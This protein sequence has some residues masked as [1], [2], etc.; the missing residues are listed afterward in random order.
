[1]SAAATADG[2]LLAPRAGNSGSGFSHAMRGLF[3]ENGTY[4]WSVQAVDSSFTGSV[5]A[6]EQT[7]VVKPLIYFA[8]PSYSIAEGNTSRNLEIRIAG[9]LSGH[10]SVNYSVTGGT[11]TN[12]QDFSL[13]SGTLSFAP[14]ETSKNITVT[15]LD[16]SLVEWNETV[17]VSLS[18]PLGA[19]LGTPSQTTLTITD[20]DSF[21]ETPISIATSIG[22]TAAW[23]D[24][25]NDGD[26]DIAVAGWDAST[27]KATFR[28]FRNSPS[29]N[30][31]YSLIT[32]TGTI[33]LA[34][35]DRP[36]L[37]WI[38]YDRDGN[39]DLFL[40]G[41][42]SPSESIAKIYRN[43]AANN[44][45]T[46][47]F[48][49]KNLPIYAGRQMRGGW[50]DLEGNGSLDLL[51]AGQDSMGSPKTFLYKNLT[52]PGGTGTFETVTGHNLPSLRNAIIA[53]ADYDNDGDHDLFFSGILFDKGYFHNSGLYEN[54]GFGNLSLTSN[55]F[56]GVSHGSAAWGD[57][58]NDG[59]L[60]LLISGRTDM[61]DEE[62]CVTEI[63]RNNQDDTF[64]LIDSGLPGSRGYGSSWG[65]YNNDGKLD[66]FVTG[67]IEAPY[68]RV[69]QNFD[70]DEFL[71]IAFAFP[72][73]YTGPSAWGHNNY[74]ADKGLDLM[75]LTATGLKVYN[76]QTT[77]NTAPTTPTGLVATVSGTS[78]TLSWNASTDTTTPTSGLTYNVRL[79][80]TTNNQEA[81][82]SM[83]NTTTGF[84]RVPEMGNVGHLR[85]VTIYN[86]KQFT[87]YTWSVQAVDA[88]YT[89][90]SF[91]GSVSFTT[92]EPSVLFSS[93]NVP[94]GEE[95][96]E[97][98]VT[99]RLTE[100]ILE[101]VT[102]E[103]KTVS[104]IAV[105]KDPANP[106]AD[107]D[108]ET[109]TG[110]LTFE[111]K[112]VTQTFTVKINDD[113]LNEIPETI[114]LEL[115]N[116]SNI[117]LVPGHSSQITIADNDVQPEVNFTTDTT[118]VD[119][120]VGVITLTAI[121]NHRSGRETS[122]D[123][124]LNA[125]TALPGQDY[126][127]TSGTLVFLEGEI[128]KTFTITILEDLIDEDPQ[129]FTAELLNPVG[130][131]L[132]DPSI[133]VITIIG[134]DVPPVASILP[135][136]TGY[137]AQ[138]GVHHEV[139]VTVVLSEASER[140]IYV[141]YEV[142]ADGDTATSGS[143]YEDTRGRL[144]F[145]PGST[146]RTFT[147]PIINDTIYEREIQA[148]SLVLSKPPGSDYVSIAED[149]GDTLTIASDDEIPT[150]FFCETDFLGTKGM[151]ALFEV[152]LSH[153]SDEDVTINYYTTSGTAKAGEDYHQ[154]TDLLVIK[155]G[156]KV[157]TFQVFLI[158]DYEEDEH[159]YFIARL[160]S[161]SGAI[162]GDIMEAKMW[163]M[164][165]FTQRIYVPGITK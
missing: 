109:A 151:Y 82:S 140:V 18:S 94:V 28:L 76:N 101:T 6:D 60:D 130:L 108:Y 62:A 56:T 135:H 50:G 98:T 34:V 36:H 73:D 117:A 148:A 48:E 26:M 153:L 107:Y 33:P 134:Q 84:H 110:T 163:F 7:L 58:D 90:S 164:P 114:K 13:S 104:V 72:G 10:T 124:K 159:E 9:D 63:Y 150:V 154:V 71:E 165:L 83:S 74:A 144:T 65:D 8:M 102:V 97:A 146:S 162:R 147:I 41:S 126:T 158:N 38:D 152:E 111:P 136:P 77:T 133:Q 145:T 67:F 106:T 92:T 44:T 57:Y 112:V 100:P 131:E 143:D 69:F 40:M 89:P 116:A 54:D 25:D 118:T 59:Y 129:S 93:L 121:L 30:P 79:G 2:T 14:N 15:I 19:F 39:P 3:L 16:D 75:V 42:R 149:G 78:V 68:A 142:G 87:S 12:G 49:D 99:V 47:V 88:S 66:L 5:F 52:Q 23:S 128:E 95:G 20:N 161:P 85:S 81:V 132:V 61:Y 138:E 155:A 45:T 125:G 105:P 29:A 156:D 120:G 31:Q 91:A 22:E 113:V 37:Q 137:F 115:E 96:G 80:T 17:I 1:M 55:T 103:Y 86:L 4:Y 127:H 21:V 43:I 139:V 11:A 141:D 27:D 157:N 122:I 119:E 160:D 123:Y 53:W 51:V 46:L 35:Y 24:F 32:L 64:T 70:N